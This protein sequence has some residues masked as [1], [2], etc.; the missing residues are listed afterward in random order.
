MLNVVDI[1][2]EFCTVTM[3]I[4]ADLKQHVM[5]DVYKGEWYIS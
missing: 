1:V 4:T 3:F 2:S 5:H